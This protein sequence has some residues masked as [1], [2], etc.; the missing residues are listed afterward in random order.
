MEEY[1]TLINPCQS[2]PYSIVRLTGIT[3]EMVSEAPT[4]KEVAGTI[5]DLTKD[6]IFVA[7]NVNFDYGFIRAEFERLGTYY[8]RKKLCTVRLSRQLLP[9]KFSYSLGKLCKSE[10]IPLSDRHRA[11]GDAK[12][13]TILFERLL[14][15][16]SEGIIAKS[17]NP[18]SLEALLPPNLPKSDFLGLP[19][20]QGIYYFKDQKKRIVY[21]GKAKNIKK[22]VHSHFSGNSNTKGKYHFVKNIHAVDFQ[23]VPNNLLLDLVEAAEI[24]KYWP[25]YNRAMKRITLNYGLFQYEDR[26]GYYRFSNG[27]SGKHDRPLKSFKSLDYLKSFLREI[28]REYQLCPR[29]S[30]L[31]PISHGK[32]NY[33]EDLECKGACE[34]KEKAASYNLRHIQ[35]VEE[36]VNENAS[37]VIRELEKNG[38]NQAVVL[39]E[40]GRYKGFGKFPIDTDLTNL[41]ALKSNLQG[42]Y[43]DQD[44]S[45]LVQAY[46]GKAK[47]ED[48]VFL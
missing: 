7:H 39:V 26:N 44:L 22:R 37:Y 21:I 38:S 17:L 16:D 30:G 20:A 31:Q 25:R 23:L 10:G 18:Q 41:Q 19:N 4:F 24:K 13:T 48:V 9:G 28:V 42:A 43:D 32:C 29:L 11:A 46:L 27:R 15:R 2:I 33:I 45:H 35:A 1:Q 40:K 12:A 14:S 8:K 3:D 36:R 47:Q 5:D 34:Q 6:C